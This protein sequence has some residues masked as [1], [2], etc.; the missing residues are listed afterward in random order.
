MVARPAG[1]S[2]P[3]ASRR[4]SRR[5]RSAARRPSV[6]S[7]SMSDIWSCSRPP[8]GQYPGRPRTLTSVPST[9]RTALPPAP[10]RALTWRRASS[11][12]TTGRVA[13]GGLDRSPPGAGSIRSN[14]TIRPDPHPPARPPPAA[15]WRR[16]PAADSSAV[17]GGVGLSPGTPLPRPRLRLRITPRTHTSSGNVRR[18]ATATASPTSVTDQVGSSGSSHRVWGVGRAFGT[19]P[20]LATGYDGVGRQIEAARGGGR[21]RA[22]VP[23]EAD[24]GLGSSW[25]TRR[26]LPAYCR[27]TPCSAGGSRSLPAT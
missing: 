9:M 27:S 14:Q 16:R 25:C 23:V 6:K 20:T 3:S 7:G 24:P 15:P 4:R 21:G 11:N 8:R 12:K 17:V 18:R 19:A 1:A 5:S 26:S 22:G 2:S 10:S 13:S